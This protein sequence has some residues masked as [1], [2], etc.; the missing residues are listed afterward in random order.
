MTIANGPGENDLP[1]LGLPVDTVCYIIVKAREFDAK[2]EEEVEDEGS[3]P[4]D[5]GE[6]DV[7]ADTADDPVD[8]ELHEAIHALNE[9]EQLALVAL[10]WLGRGD[11]DISEWSE[12]LAL[13]HERHRGESADYL[14]G[15]PLLGDYLEEGLAA[16]DRDCEGTEKAH[17]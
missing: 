12:A 1:E 4:V 16:F 17:L 5:D 3:D 11:F 15:M 2:A 10:A 8:E 14:I 6:I 9:D 7:L 13:A